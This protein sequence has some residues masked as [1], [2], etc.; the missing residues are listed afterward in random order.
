M[1]SMSHFGVQIFY[2]LYATS[3]D[4]DVDDEYESD[5]EEYLEVLF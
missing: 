2:S 1:V 3:V 5:D 4:S